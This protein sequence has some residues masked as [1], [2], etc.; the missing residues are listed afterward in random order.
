[1]LKSINADQRPAE[2]E[3]LRLAVLDRPDIH[4]LE[5][6]LEAAERDALV[7]ECDCYVSLHRAEGLGL[8]I[9]EAMAYGKP[10]VATGY[11]G[12][13]Q[14][15]TEQNS[16]LV[17]WAPTTIP[18]GAA[19][20]PAGGTWAEPDLDAAATLLRLVL[21]EPDRAAAR[22]RQAA[23]DIAERHSPV[24]AGAAVAARLTE[25]GAARRDRSRPRPWTRVR[26][27]VQR[28]RAAVR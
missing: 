18:S 16:F 3:H 12:N 14:F 2:A 28:L 24:M 10:V 4:L 19:P 9:A 13:L 27:I 1:V 20:Y 23:A 26:E 22:A 15:M 11:S 17:P 8:T 25:L 21:D 5:D 6:Y 7:A